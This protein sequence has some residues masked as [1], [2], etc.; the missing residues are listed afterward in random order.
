MKFS[1]S[2]LRCARRRLGLSQKDLAKMAQVS[3]KVVQRAETGKHVPQ[4]ETIAALAAILHVE[5]GSL[6]T[7]ETA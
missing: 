7:E 4:P 5:M 3:T 2:Q 1:P 6:F